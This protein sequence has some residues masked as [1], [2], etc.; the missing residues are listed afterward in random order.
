MAKPGGAPWRAA[1]RL[2]YEA[3]PR[4][5]DSLA[6]DA[7]RHA[8]TR[9]PQPTSHATPSERSAD[10]HLLTKPAPPLIGKLA[11]RAAYSGA[12]AAY[13]TPTAERLARRRLSVER[14]EEVARGDDGDA[15]VGTQGE[16]GAVA[17]DEVGGA[18]G[19]GGFEDGV[20]VR[21]GGDAGHAAR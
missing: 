11:S 4:S 7:S 20:V 9:P 17:G 6:R 16:E 5:D 14:G 12:A 18:A 13:R 8:G 15:L 21:V 1:Q 2:C 19:D 10:A 3:T